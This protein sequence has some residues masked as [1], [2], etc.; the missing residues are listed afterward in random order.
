MPK[1][2]YITELEE[3]MVLAEDVVD[4]KNRVLLEAGT[5]ITLSDISMLLTK[6]V[7]Y[8]YVTTP[9]AEEEKTQSSSEKEKIPR[10]IKRLMQ[11]LNATDIEDLKAKLSQYLE[12]FFR[13]KKESLL[14]KRL[15]KESIKLVVEG[16]Y[17]V[18]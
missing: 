4:S 5:T 2:V 16:K 14:T 10:H 18:K 3:G 1:K 17:G 6:G 11:K 8:V 13:F 9:Q 7:L 12:R 15:I